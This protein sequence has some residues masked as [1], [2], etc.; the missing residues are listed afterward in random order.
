MRGDDVANLASLGKLESLSADAA[1]DSHFEEII[2]AQFKR[3]STM[4]DDEKPKKL[5]LKQAAKSLMS[6]YRHYRSLS[7]NPAHASL[8]ALGR[9][10]RRVRKAPGK[11]FFEWIIVPQFKPSE[12]VDALNWACEALLVVCTRPVGRFPKMRTALQIRGFSKRNVFERDAR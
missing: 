5:E 6:A 1:A 10:F 4:Y 11:T 8:S 2:D 3:F 12:R 7:H 9:H